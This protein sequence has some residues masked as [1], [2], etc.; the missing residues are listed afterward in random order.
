MKTFFLL[1]LLIML[2]RMVLV[3]EFVD[4]ILKHE[5]HLNKLI[6]IEQYFPVALF[7]ELCKVVLLFSLWMKS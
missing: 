3:L 5:S 2:Y 1:A 6:N 4:E 7:I